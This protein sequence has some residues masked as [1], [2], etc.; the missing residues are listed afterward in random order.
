MLINDV[1]IPEAQS[2]LFATKRFLIKRKIGKR[3]ILNSRRNP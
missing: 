1:I 3:F 2:G